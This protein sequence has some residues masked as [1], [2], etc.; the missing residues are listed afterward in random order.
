MQLPGQGAIAGLASHG[1]ALWLLRGGRLLRVAWPAGEVVASVE[2]QDARGLCADARFLYLLRGREI[3][4]FDAQAQ[5][6][7]RTLPLALARRPVAIAAHAGALQV[8]DERHL[9]AVDPRTGALTTGPRVEGHLL[10]WLA[11]DGQTLWGG[12]G[13][14]CLPVL[15]AEP[16]ANRWR[17]RRWP[18]LLQ[19][20]VATWIDGKLLLSAS[21]RGDDRKP[22]EVVG[23]LTPSP[24]S[25]REGWTLRLLRE[26]EGVRYELGTSGFATLG[27]LQK[28]LQR[29]AADASLRVPGPD[30]R[31]WPRR[32]VLDPRPGVLVREVLAA[33]EAVVTSGFPD[34]GCPAQ[35][36]WVRHNRRAASDGAGR[37]R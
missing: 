11:S 32:I 6:V 24:E 1:G 36:A 28:E 27:L 21:Y 17:G 8:A 3:A 22:V 37:T 2:M 29:L 14:D 13:V 26:G 12:D 23:L 19:D 35:E 31:S 18:W 16:A 5:Q 10:Q 33:W 30:G 25:R 20:G 15:A 7:M 9:V 4:V 34:V